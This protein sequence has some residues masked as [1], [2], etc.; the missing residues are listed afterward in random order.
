MNRE[1]HGTIPYVKG[2]EELINKAYQQHTKCASCT[3]GKSTLEDFRELRTSADKPLKQV[4]I[5][6]FSCMR[7]VRS[8]SIWHASIASAIPVSCCSMEEGWPKDSYAAYR[9]TPV[10]GHK[11][12]SH[13]GLL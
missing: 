1:I 2:L 6:S 5:N 3:L 13:D 10:L 4:N 7:M 12:S 8:S 11:R 9:Q